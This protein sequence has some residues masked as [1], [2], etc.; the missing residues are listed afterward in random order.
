M[1]KRFRFLLL[2]AVSVLLAL[3]LL[4]GC[5]S[6]HRSPTGLSP[7]DCR[8]A[9]G[10]VGGALS[11]PGGHPPHRLRSCQRRHGAAILGRGCDPGG[12]GFHAALR[13]PLPA[14]GTALR[15][16]PGRILCGLPFEE[17]GYGCYAPVIAGVLEEQLPPKYTVHFRI[18][19]HHP[20]ALPKLCSETRRAGADLGHHRPGGANPRHPMAA[21]RRQPLYLEEERTLHGAHRQARDRYLCQDPYESHG[22]VSLPEDLLQL[23]FEQMGSQAVAVVQS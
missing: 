11:F 16:K 6:P 14:E 2:G 21:G 19:L 18:R 20:P 13:S 12:G 8:I 3:S 4:A 5:A 9:G 22:T 10:T 1:K 15:P 17:T 7:A 23:R